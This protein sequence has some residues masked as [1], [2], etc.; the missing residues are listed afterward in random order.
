MRMTTGLI[1]KAEVYAIQGAVFEVYYKGEAIEK[2]YIPD[3]RLPSDA[4][5]AKTRRERSTR[6]RM[7]LNRIP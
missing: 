5:I 4:G 1:Y 3:L 6:P 7:R 2:T